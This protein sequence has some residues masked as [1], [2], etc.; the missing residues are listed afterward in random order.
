ML[1]FNSAEMGPESRLWSAREI[2]SQWGPIKD[3]LF[4][5]E[6]IFEH[7]AHFIYFSHANESILRQENEH[8]W[9]LSTK[10][11]MCMCVHACVYVC[12]CVHMWD[13]VRDFMDNQDAS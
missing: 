2:L 4:Q 11:I 6:D 3:L 13:L 9:W 12:T 5:N 10:I 8:S 7:L 1:Q